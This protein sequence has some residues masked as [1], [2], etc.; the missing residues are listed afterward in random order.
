MAATYRNASTSPWT[1][2]L[3]ARVAELAAQGLTMQKIGDALGM[4][5]NQIIGWRSRNCYDGPTTNDRLDAMHA[6]MDAALE[7]VARGKP[8][9]RK[10]A[11]IS[12]SILYCPR[13]GEANL[14]QGTVTVFSRLE[15]DSAVEITRILPD[16][17]GQRWMATTSGPAA[18]LGNPSSRRNGLVIEFECES[19]SCIEPVKFQIYQHNGST[20]VEWSEDKASGC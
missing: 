5:K 1:P 18:E 3:Q 19:E 2:E 13:C 11:I 17:R 14:H 6:K 9:L 16:G 7:I 15:D 10:T 20:F 4:T 8:M 12:D